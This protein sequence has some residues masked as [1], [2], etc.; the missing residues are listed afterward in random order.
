MTTI[1]ESDLTAALR[2]VHRKITVKI[3]PGEFTVL[4]YA[5]ANGCEKQAAV[6]LVNEGVKSGL[7]VQVGQRTIA[8]HATNVYRLKTDTEV[9]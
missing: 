4:M 1:T 8:G 9:L 6:T 7:I 3:Q 5:E 2:E